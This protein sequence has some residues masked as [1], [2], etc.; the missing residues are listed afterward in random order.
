MATIRFTGDL[1]CSPRMIQLAGGNFDS[2]FEKSGLNTCDYLVGNPESPFAGEEMK[3]T[4][5]RYCFNTPTAFLHAMKKAGFDLVSMANN[6]CMDR[7]EAGI[8]NTLENCRKAGLDTVGLYATQEDRDRIFIKTLDGIRVAFVNYTYGINAFVHHSFLEHPYMVNLFQPEETR[9]GSVHLLNHRSTVAADVA[10]IYDPASPE[11]P[12]VQPYL[13]QLRGDLRR[14]KEQADFVVMLMHCGGQYQIEVDAY[15]HLIADTVKE[16]GAD[17]IIGHHQHIL[18][19]SEHRDGFL[20]TFSLGN[21]L[22]DPVKCRDEYRFTDHEFGAVV[23]LTL[24]R[25]GDGSITAE[26][27]FRIYTTVLDCHDMPQIRNAYEVAMHTG[28]SGL[29][30][31]ILRWANLFAGEEKFTAIQDVYPF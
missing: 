17:I 1:L 31:E 19:R 20:T 18:Q 27:S 30:T 29:T 6:H 21:L 16:A 2:V 12:I 25:S 23:D 22:S 7:G 14:A 13:E 10:R 15:T 28:D 3:Y 8:L 26:K 4:W 9:P 24:R 5:E 11:F